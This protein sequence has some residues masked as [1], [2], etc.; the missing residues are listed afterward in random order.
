MRAVTVPIRK[1]Q[2]TNRQRFLMDM[3]PRGT[4]TATPTL[5][6]DCET[7]GR[8]CRREFDQAGWMP[9]EF[10][11]RTMSRTDGS[12]WADF[13]PPR[14]LTAARHPRTAPFAMLVVSRASLLSS[15]LGPA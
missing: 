15:W 7:N 2:T 13:V 3:K 8:D 5:R 10:L 4:K 11:A 12:S 6:N 9:V 14:R 1:P